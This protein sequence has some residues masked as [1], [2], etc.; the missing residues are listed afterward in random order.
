MNGNNGNDSPFD[1]ASELAYTFPQQNTDRP[2]RWASESGY[3]RGLGEDAGE[4]AVMIQPAASV[5]RPWYQTLVDTL[6][7]AAASVYQQRELTKLNTERLR[8]G[9]PMIT[10][11][12]FARTYQPPAAQVQ[13]GMTDG[14]KKMMM[15]GALG[16]G[17]YVALKALKIIR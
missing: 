14:T 4:A 3:F 2:R 1:E 12:E 10:A 13:F 9:M 15:Y 17:A 6:V 16:L 7:P 11:S 5:E 8:A